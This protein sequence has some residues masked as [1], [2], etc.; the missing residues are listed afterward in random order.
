MNESRA[1]LPIAYPDRM[2]LS[3]TPKNHTLPKKLHFVVASR[4]PRCF[5]S[6]LLMQETS[7][8]SPSTGEGWGEGERPIRD[9]LPLNPI[10]PR[11][12]KFLRSRPERC[13]GTGVAISMQLMA[14]TLRRSIK[15]LQR[16][17]EPTN[18]LSC[19]SAPEL[20]PRCRRTVRVGHQHN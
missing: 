15:R 10:P 6:V 8:P 5:A 2:P 17:A 18:T 19:K 3:S 12:G 20:Q 11:E 4:R 1:S 7:I 9:P 14:R 13:E 16:A